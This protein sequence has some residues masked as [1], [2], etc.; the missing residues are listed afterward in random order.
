MHGTSGPE[1]APARLSLRHLATDRSIA[2]MLGLG[3]SSGIPFLL[4]YATQSAW[5]SEAQ[6][7]LGTLGL[8]SELTIAYK[9]KFVWA[10]FLDQYDPPV[11]ARFLGRRRAWIVVSQIG[12][13]L[14]LAGIAFGDPAQRL[15]WTVAFSLALGFAGAT[16]DVVID[17]WRITVAPPERQSLMSAWAEVGWRAGSFAAGAGTLY[18]ADAIGWRGAYLCMAALMMPGMVAALLAPEPD[19]DRHRRP[20][21]KGFVATV[22]DPIRDLMRR[23]G[24]LAVPVLLLVAGFRMPGYVSTAMAIPLFKH[25]HYA[26]SEIATVTKLF[27]FWVALAGTFLAGVTVPRVGLMPSLLAGTVFASA[28][29]LA[30]AYLAAHGADAP[31]GFWTF[32]VAVSIDSFAYAFAS[33][34]LITYMS[35]IVAT[36][37]AASQYA[38]L[39]SLCALPGSLLAG[40]SGFAVERVGFPWFFVGTSLIGIPVAVLCGYVRYAQDRP[41]R[42]ISA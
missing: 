34:V 8:M 33:I 1:G 18:L 15:A 25:L 12:V 28:S 3:F 29:H 30:L 16:Q 21:R 7:P 24:P 38:L 36:E 11:L 5:L 2:A 13:M 23:L 32:A 20:D 9:F 19:S 17:G 31:P 27:G 6:V 26:D 39:T 14:T 40:V 4:V 10:P 41:G 22:A 35:G 37:H 42:M